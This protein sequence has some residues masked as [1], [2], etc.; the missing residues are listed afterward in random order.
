MFISIN[1]ILIIINKYYF[2]QLI[3]MNKFICQI[4]EL[5]EKLH[6]L[7]IFLKFKYLFFYLF[8]ISLHL[9]I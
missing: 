5:E 1:F 4:N 3:E 7:I 9:Y 2:H 8:F 6:F